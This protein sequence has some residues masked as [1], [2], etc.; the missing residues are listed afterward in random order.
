MQ[1]NKRSPIVFRFEILSA[2]VRDDGERAIQFIQI[3]D[4]CTMARHRF[5]SRSLSFYQTPV[6][7]FPCRSGSNKCSFE[8]GRFH[9]S[10]FIKNLTR[11]NGGRISVFPSWQPCRN[12]VQPAFTSV[13]QIVLVIVG[14]ASPLTMTHFHDMAKNAVFK[15]NV[16]PF[17][18]ARVAKKQVS[19]RDIVIENI[20]RSEWREGRRERE[21]RERGKKMQ[22]LRG[23]S[24]ARIL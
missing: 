4:E 3:D 2:R 19:G 7:F 20:I 6:I 9:R 1:F 8:R 10:N 13:K 18:S 17:L 11:N 14:D 15:C 21:R 5:P 16:V 24:Q 12:K 22:K 23:I